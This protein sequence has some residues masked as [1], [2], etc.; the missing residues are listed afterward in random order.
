MAQEK[1][2]LLA[3]HLRFDEGIKDEEE[4]GLVERLQAIIDKI[5]EKNIDKNSHIISKY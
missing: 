2:K 5:K 4:L 3:R 1:L